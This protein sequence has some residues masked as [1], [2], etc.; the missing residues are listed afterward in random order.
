MYIYIIFCIYFFFFLLRLNLKTL[1]ML[2]VYSTTELYPPNLRMHIL[3]L[4]IHM[5]REYGG[6]WGAQHG[7]LDEPTESGYWGHKC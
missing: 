1:H 5:H 3:I 7:G 4:S 2:S 6:I